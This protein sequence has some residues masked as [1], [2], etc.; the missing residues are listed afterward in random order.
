MR[1]GCQPRNSDHRVLVAFVG[2]VVVDRLGCAT[3]DGIGRYSILGPPFPDPR[4]PGAIEVDDGT[5]PFDGPS[6]AHEFAGVLTPLIVLRR[7]LE[8]FP[9]LGRVI[10][11]AVDDG[12]IGVIDF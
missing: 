2:A 5:H 12:W 3:V 11:P 4:N 9:I 10:S 8:G 7:R 1:S 6:A